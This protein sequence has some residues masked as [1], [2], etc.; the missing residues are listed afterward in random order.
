[1]KLDTGLAWNQTTAMLSAN[2]T[3]ILTVAAVFFFLPNFALMLF[4]PPDQAAIQSALDQG[5]SEQALAAIGAYF[6][7]TWWAYVLIAVAQAIGTLGLMIMLSKRSEL[8]LGQALGVAAG[9][10]LPFIAS[11]VLASLIFGAIL[12]VAVALIA[13]AGATGAQALVGLV[14]LIAIIAAVV[15][16]L[17][18]YTKLSLVSAVF[19]Y[20][21][22]KNP[23]SAL[24]ASWRATKGNS[25]RI[26]A[27]FILLL[28]AFIVISSV[29]S[30][31]TGA[32][33]ALMGA[34]AALIGNGFVGAATGAALTVV[35]TVVVLAIYR[36]LS[37]DDAT[38]VRETFE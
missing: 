30:L 21:R 11:Q 35:L 33:F 16:I 2:R 10:L 3:V 1:M 4:Y 9:L 19:A 5:G 24:K 8:T 23:I 31:V 17:Y 25:V 18:V 12:A 38:T 27:F 28:I 20:V 37:G 29:I 15:A 22:M 7:Q 6:G 34:Q 32:I 36:Q 14:A 26:I 13:A